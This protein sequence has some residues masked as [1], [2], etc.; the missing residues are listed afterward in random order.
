[1]KTQETN[2]TSKRRRN[3]KK[4]KEE[5]SKPKSKNAF[6]MLGVDL[7][8]IEKFI[9]NG[10]KDNQEMLTSDFVTKVVKPTT[11]DKQIALA[12]T[13][14]S[15]LL[16]DLNKGRDNKKKIIFV[17]HA[18][19]YRIKDVLEALIEF[20]MQNGFKKLYVWFDI[21]IINQH[22]IKDYPSNFFT[23][24]FHDAIKEIGHTV[25]V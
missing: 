2:K 14:N 22:K 11:V 1:M 21:M 8:F 23:D 20:K 6:P 13:I 25:F 5:D 16:Y 7:S 3:T 18:W 15:R 19:S 12:D 4:K 24:T 10:I 9:K 17:S